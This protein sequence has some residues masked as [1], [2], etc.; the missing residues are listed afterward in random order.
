MWPCKIISHIQVVVTNFFPPPPIKLK[1][2]L[3]VGGRLLIATHFEQSNYL[4]NQKQG[5]VN[6]YDLIVFITL[7]LGSSRALKVCAF[8]QGPS[9]LPVDSLGSTDEPHPR[10]PE[11]GHV[12]SVGGEA[13]T[14]RSQQMCMLYSLIYRWTHQGKVKGTS[15]S[16]IISTKQQCSLGFGNIIQGLLQ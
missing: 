13:L 6:K 7:L 3:Q 4:A 9:S 1:L 15:L 2:G 16:L 12:L 10:F 14:Q 8:L 5:T 11:Q